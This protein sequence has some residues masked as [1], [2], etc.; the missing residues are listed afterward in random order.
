[1]GLLLLCNVVR[2]KRVQV[3]YVLHWWCYVCYDGVTGAVW[4][5]IAVQCGQMK[6]AQ[7]LHVLHWWCYVCYDGVTGALW[8]HHCCAM[9]SE[10]VDQTDGRLRYVDRAV[11]N[12]LSQ[13]SHA[14]FITL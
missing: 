5:T 1:M 12:G 13:V 3:L 4:P 7:V 14:V 2:V 11:F 9:W 8:A 10:T 6:R